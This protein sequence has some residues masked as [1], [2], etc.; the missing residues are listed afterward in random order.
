M[1]NGSLIFVLILIALGVLFIIYFWPSVALM[2]FFAIPMIKVTVVMR[3]PFLVHMVGY[4]LDVGM[5][6]IA[7]LS[8]VVY[9]WRIKQPVRILIPKLFWLCWFVLSILIWVRLPASRDYVTGFQRGMLFSVY[10]TLIILLG[11][12]YCNSF[13]AVDKMMKAFLL[14]GTVCIFGILFFGRPAGGYEASRLMFANAP[15]L[16]ISDFI[17]YGIFVLLTFWLAKRKF[18]LTKLLIPFVAFGVLAIFLTGT[19]GTILGLVVSSFFILYAYR[20]NQGIMT[21]IGGLVLV[22]V[23]GVVANFFLTTKSQAER[24]STEIIRNDVL[25]RVDMVKSTLSE[26]LKSPVFGTGTGDTSFQLT[27]TTGE[28]Q[29]PHNIYL[30][31]LNELGIVGFVFYVILLAHSFRVIKMAVSYQLDN[32]IPREFLVVITAGLIYQL[33]LSAKGGSYIGGDLYFFLGAGVSFVEMARRQL[34]EREMYDY[35]STDL[36]E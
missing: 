3:F 31:L 1:A 18:S 30:E 20:K 6:L 35:E 8:I 34:V 12:L 28:R 16:A 26:W 11:A 27:G 22:V 2:I 36:Q 10:D 19:R 25:I 5:L 17:G 29:Y 4:I 23:I 9:H 24:F 15:S 13:Q 32:V 21:I 7:L 33:L 14:S